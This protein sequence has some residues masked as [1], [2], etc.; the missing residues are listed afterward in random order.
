MR[1]QE[2]GAPPPPLLDPRSGPLRSRV[3][4]TL[5]HFT[6]P[7]THVR[8]CLPRDR[9]LFAQV[10]A[11]WSEVEGAS[12]PGR[13]TRPSGAGRP[14]SAHPDGSR[15]PRRR[16][17]RG[18]ARTAR[19]RRSRDGDR[20]PVER[21]WGKIEVASRT[22]GGTCERRS[23]AAAPRTHATTSRMQ[24][25]A[26]RSSL[27]RRA[28]G[29]G[30]ARSPD[31][32]AR[33]DGLGHRGQARRRAHRRSPC[34]SPRATCSSRTCPGV[35]KTMLA[36]ALARS[37]DCSVRRI[38]FTPD[39]L[40]SDITGVSVFNQDVR[41]FEFRPGRDL[42]QRRRRRRD[43]P[44]LAQDPVRAAR[45]AWRRA[46]SPSTARPTPARRRSS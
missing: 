33:G 22:A 5:L 28:S 46:R 10:S 19:D 37:I 36:K 26:A 2:H 43:Q 13:R 44:R 41:D 35:G 18:R 14:T 6:P 32:I 9:R 38:Q 45:V 1:T 31:G 27:D 40:P 23:A 3:R 12:R 8:P 11:R 24:D 34:C 42:R 15:R 20:C 17:G 7:S 16:L 29:P 25:G 4:P 39:L 21:Q 30:R